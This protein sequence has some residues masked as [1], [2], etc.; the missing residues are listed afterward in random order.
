MATEKR[1]GKGAGAR[2]NQASGD[3][4]KGRMVL[5]D[6]RRKEGGPV[7]SARKP[8]RKGV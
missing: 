2:E 3:H 4:E 1:A 7:S 6:H 8:E 5:G